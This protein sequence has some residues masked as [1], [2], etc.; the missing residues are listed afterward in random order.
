[1]FHSH[2]LKTPILLTLLAFAFSNTAAATDWFVAV[3]GSDQATTSGSINAPFASISRV[4]LQNSFGPGDTVYV[5][6]GTYSLVQEQQISR[7]GTAQAPV[8]VRP[9]LN[10]TVILDGS[11]LPPSEPAALTVLASHVVVEGFNLR[12]STGIGIQIWP[13]FTPVENV[14]IRNNTIRDC[15]KSGLF[16]GQKLD[17]TT[18][19]VSNIQILN[20]TLY[21]NVRENQARTWDSNW[22]PTLGILYSQDIIVQGNQVYENYGEGISIMQSR[23]VDV[24]RNVVHDNYSVNLYIDGGVQT[25]HEGNLVYSTGQQEYFRDFYHTPGRPLLPA[26]GIQIANESWSDWSNPLTSSDNTIV[27]NIFIA[28]RAALIYGNYQSGGGL[29]NVLFAFN[30]IYN[31]AET[32]L[33]ID[34]DVHANTEIANNIWV[35]LG[36]AP[37]TWLS[38]DA[39]GFRF[40]HNLWF[41][42][43]PES[44]VQSSTDVYADPAFVRAG[45]Y[46]AADYVLQSA[47]PAIAAGQASTTITRDYAGKPRPNPPTLGAFESKNN[48][49]LA[50]LTS[51]GGIYY[52]NNL[53]SWINIP[54]VL[55]QLVTGDFNGDGK[56][57]LAGLTSAGNIYYTTNLTSWTYLPGILNKLVTGDFNG[58]G[59]TDLAGLTSVG[60]IYYSNNLTSWINIP[61]AL[62][63]LVAG[64]FNGDGKT[65]LAGLTSAGQIFYSTNLANWTYLPGILNKL[66]TGDFNGDGKTDLA[67]LTSA[68]QIFYSTNLLHWASI[69]GQLNKLVTGDFNGDGKTDLAGLTGAGNIYYTTNLTSWTY[70][71]GIL[72]KLVTGDFNGDGKTD[73]AGLTSAGQIFYST[74]LLHWAS[75]IGQLNKLAGGTD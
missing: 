68:G 49:I 64:D 23:R 54:G 15:Q 65:D 42:S 36:G 75:I 32:A 66:V 1:M 50:G 70:L 35:Q 61:G 72:N 5:R 39:S 22:H 73:L 13:N 52:S 30:T 63:Q 53:T 16:I 14:V 2:R 58:D 71:P 60:G 27:N 62:A 21:H 57:D 41:G 28:N 10:E 25:R 38:G 8:T 74:N 55:A 44:I 4:F 48:V 29:N 26:S 31:H 67:G 18:A 47:S 12:N 9:Y 51:A 11:G 20:N 56:T 43:V 3:N 24:S 59:K 34:P 7:G 46:V 17:H 37:Q 45:S 6:G 69:I 40:H 19:G 33:Q